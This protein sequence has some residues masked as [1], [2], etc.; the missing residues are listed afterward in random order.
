MKSPPKSNG[1]IVPAFRPLRILLTALSLLLAS[2]NLHAAPEIVEPGDKVRLRII[3]VIDQSYDVSL[4][5]T[6]DFDLMGKVHIA[7]MNRT[8][9]I[10]AIKKSLSKYIKFQ[11]KPVYLSIKKKVLKRQGEVVSV[12]GEVHA[13]DSYPYKRHLKALDYIVL[14][15]GTTRFALTDSIKVICTTKGRTRSNEFNLQQ[16]SAGASTAMPEINPGCVIYVP[17]KPAEVASWMRNRPHQ[18]I[19]V[20][21]EVNKPGRYEFSSKFSFMDILSH[22]GGFTY[23]A[24][25]SRVSI[26]THKIVRNF[27][28]DAYLT[29]GGELPHLHTR[30]VI[31][32]PKVPKSHSADWTKI[33]SKKSIYLVGEF[34]R[35]G[36]YDFLPSL[37]FL[38]FFAQS[39]GATVNADT[40]RI[41]IIRR[42]KVVQ[43]FNFYRYRQ[44]E[45]RTLPELRAEDLVYIPAI[46]PAKWVKGNPLRYVNVMGEV[47]RP[48]RFDV[49]IE[50]LNLIDILT[51]AAGP[52]NQADL[53]A[54]R[55]ISREVPGAT[56][57]GEAKPRVTVFDFEAYQSEGG[58]GALPPI[59]W[60]DTVFI[61]KE[62]VS[63][64]E[65]FKTIGGSLGV[66][67]SII[68]IAL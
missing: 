67:L 16:F 43:E 46:E 56:D 26:I 68:A 45:S 32:V 24:D 58:T 38:D 9:A 62:K 28:L 55:I 35:P 18:V 25:T 22:A 2:T 49:E 4:R 29:V 40:K 20:I 15:G 13:P 3:G 50:N 63:F 5:G 42:K 11:N 8:Q 47:N 61:S 41:K 51:A 10:R 64:W 48:G 21:G 34:R 60:G 66:V 19:H 65:E 14:S 23:E 44:G 59:Q 33:P 17:E 37:G 30:D 54:I 39:G 52:K 53:S 36:R 6:I 31:Y 7:G 12:F 57:G 27:D 1:A